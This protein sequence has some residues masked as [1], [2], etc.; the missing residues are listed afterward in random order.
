MKHSIAHIFFEQLVILAVIVL[1]A[2][3]LEAADVAENTHGKIAVELKP[4]QSHPFIACTAEEMKRLKDAYASQGAE[5]N[6][7]AGRIAAADQALLT[8][9]AFPPEGGQHNQWYQCYKCQCPLQ[10]VEK[11]HKCPLCGAEYTGYPFD[12]VLYEREFYVLTS[13]MTDCAWAYAIT[14]DKKYSD[15]AAVIL[16]GFAKRY[17]NYEYHT[18]YT[19]TYGGKMR[20]GAPVTTKDKMA[21]Q[22]N[23]MK[24]AGGRV[25]EQTLN[26]AVWLI[27]LCAVY[28]LIHDSPSLKPNDHEM[29]RKQLIEPVC[30]SISENPD[31]KSNWQSWHNAGMLWAGA[32]LGE[33]KWADRAINDK[34]NGFI[35]Q[36]GVSLSPDG[37]WYENSFSYHFYALDA[38]MNLTEGAR[39]IGID[40]Y[41]RPEMKRALT[42]PIMYVMS[43]GTLPRSGDSTRCAPS[44]AG[45]LYEI[46]YA[47]YKD[48]SML[49]A[50]GNS[51]T[52]ESVMLGRDLSAT[53]Q[54]FEP[55]SVLLSGAGHAILRTQ[56]SK[57][58]NAILTFAEFG[59][60][61]GHFDKLSLVLYGLG[62]EIA[63]DRGRAA[64][65]AYRLPVHQNW[66]R[67]TISH[68]T[69][70]VDRI[71][72]RGV[73]AVCDLFACSDELAAAAA[74]CDKTYPGVIHRRLMCL[75]AD[76]MLVLDLLEDKSGKE[77]TFDLLYHVNSKEARCPQASG[78]AALPKEAGFEYVERAKSG[79]TGEAISV[80]FEDEQVTT[81]LTVAPGGETEI[82]TGDGRGEAVE[83]RIPLAI[84]TRKGA[85]TIFASVLEPVAAGQEAMVKGAEV[86]KSGKGFVIRVKAGEREDV[87]SYEPEPSERTVEGVK[88]KDALLCLRRSGGEA[89]EKRLSAESKPAAGK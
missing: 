6:A 39:R 75:D 77:H 47:A 10:T 33:A 79:K 63:V 46:G 53:P 42:L 29:I 16:R 76:Y 2:N 84:M 15:N 25:F 4:A 20:G 73:G 62:R 67:A 37:M 23:L 58:L 52:W 18:N 54:A 32:M 24:R 22:G 83:V 27:Q 68:N 59:G 1:A 7:V 82:I 72:Q 66:Y 50:V 80:A 14:G 55:G 69:V 34:S 57:K 71:S 26:E 19:V 81:H 88:T 3:G 74:F 49:L 36:L 60:F 51:P 85:S 43:D 8:A 64:S 78:Q 87:Y 12:H 86:V 48:P 70:L 9:N 65:Q 41:V 89:W 11:K 28:D 38:L 13:R 56:G 17:L 61:H 40:L 45:R 31:G 44:S 30:L 21:D 35:Y 5:K